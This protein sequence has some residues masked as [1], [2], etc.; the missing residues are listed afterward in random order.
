MFYFQK[1]QCGYANK[2]ERKPCYMPTNQYSSF[3]YWS[4]C[5][6]SCGNGIQTRIAVS[7]SVFTRLTIYISLETNKT[8][9]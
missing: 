7:F 9:L 8:Y 6:A 5:S 2:V 4:Q 1:S 3:G